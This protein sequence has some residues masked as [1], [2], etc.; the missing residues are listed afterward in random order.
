[1]TTNGVTPTAD[2]PPIS[3]AD[4]QKTFG[5]KGLS[6]WGG[7]VN[8]EYLTALSPWSKQVRV[9]LEMRDDPTIGTLLDVIKLPLL[10]ADLE[11]EAASVSQADM[12]ASEFLWDALNS[13]HRQTLRSFAE[14]Q[15]SALD[16]GFSVDEITLEKREDGNLWIANIDPRGQETLNR[17]HLGG[18][19]ND[20]AIAMEQ[21]SFRG[22]L[23]NPSNNIVPLA[24]SVH[25][26]FRGRKGNPQGRSLLRSVYRP[27]RFMVNM[28][29]MEG[30][31]VER[32]VGG[33]PVFTLPENPEV[34]TTASLDALDKT[35]K[36]L[37]MD[38]QMFV[39]LPFGVKMDAY[40]SS[41]KAYDI[42][43]VIDAKKKEILMRMFAQFLMLG[44]TSVG[45]QA[46]VKGSQDFFTLGL[47]SVQQNLV[48]TWNQQLVPY[49]FQFNFFP[50]MTPGQ[51][52]KIKW[53][54]PGAI[55][56]KALIESY[57]DAASANAITPIRADEEFLRSV[58]S[59]PD[60]PD[61]E[62]LGPRGQPQQIPEF[63]RL[64]KAA[65]KE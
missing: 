1:M 32:D 62:G 44:M 63:V 9:Y 38:E 8:E 45:T 27:W 36:N 29:N 43:V 40:P 7:F 30:I 14:N 58:M 13:M 6:I 26:I 31:G 2:S 11:T 33:M 25:A 56:L 39:R 54:P 52:P 59:L 57:N 50:G 53:N 4:A 61:N 15:L 18:P 55:D 22:A 19:H 24:K 3:A 64:R 12:R 51:L 42:R 65:A 41:S 20:T 47:E 16:F 10:A 35:A 5:V 60:L 37:R 28:E 17:W 46:L 49:L 21:G 48:D 23:I 34:L